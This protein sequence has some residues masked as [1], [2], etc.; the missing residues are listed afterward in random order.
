MQGQRRLGASGGRRGTS[1]KPGRGI[2]PALPRG[3]ADQFA[4]APAHAGLGWR[5]ACS[6]CQ[7][8][9]PQRGGPRAPPMQEAGAEER[10][11]GGPIRALALSAAFVLA[12]SRPLEAAPH[13]DV[14]A[15]GL[16]LLF[17]N[18]FHLTEQLLQAEGAAG[19]DRVEVRHAWRRVAALYEAQALVDLQLQARPPGPSA[20]RSAPDL[21]AQPRPTSPS[22]SP[23]APRHG[24][25]SSSA[26]P[27]A[28]ARRPQ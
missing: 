2:R 8:P 13:G 6:S 21:Q 5:P 12:R 19:L 4:A 7:H 16:V 9:L 20:S 3:G 17:D 26:T 11:P 22:A 28:T 14:A 18:A 1:A 15:R 25:A 23:P 27:P 24:G 10:S